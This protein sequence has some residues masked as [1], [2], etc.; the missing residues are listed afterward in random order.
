MHGSLLLV[1]VADKAIPDVPLA[2]DKIMT[3][4]VNGLGVQGLSNNEVDAIRQTIV[5]WTDA[6]VEG[7]LALWDS[8]WAKDSV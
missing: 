8:Y 3:V 2:G 6:L 4:N 7:D 1:I 5:S